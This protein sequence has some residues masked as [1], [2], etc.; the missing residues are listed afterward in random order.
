MI[1]SVRLFYGGQ[2]QLLSCHARINTIVSSLTPYSTYG[3]FSTFSTDPFEDSIYVGI[4]E[5]PEGENYVFN[6]TTAFN[7][8]TR[9]DGL[10]S[11]PLMSTYSIMIDPFDGS[12][13]SVNWNNVA[14]IEV[15]FN[16]TTGIL[17]SDY[18]SKC[19]YDLY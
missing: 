13:N 10:N 17:G 9:F 15:Q 18:D 19:R 2:T 6:N 5:V 1:P 16:Y 7:D 3:I 8:V 4:Y 14:D 12:N 11:L